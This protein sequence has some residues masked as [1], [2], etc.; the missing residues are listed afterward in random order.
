VSS[1]VEIM[2]QRI[3]DGLVVTDLGFGDSP[4]VHTVSVRV[5]IHRHHYGI[6]RAR[7]GE[8]EST[9]VT[10]IEASSSQARAWAGE[11]EECLSLVYEQWVADQERDDGREHCAGGC[12]LCCPGR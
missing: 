1:V 12:E 3:A 11:H 9:E 7:Y 6:D 2:A 10:V 8:I 5:T 4:E